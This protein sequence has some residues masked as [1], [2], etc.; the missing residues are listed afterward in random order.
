MQPDVIII[1]PPLPDLSIEDFIQSLRFSIETRHIP[2]AILSTE[3]RTGWKET[4]VEVIPTPVEKTYLR[5]VIG[6][7]LDK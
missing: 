5:A 3:C 4:G 6:R 2:L 7:V 1:N